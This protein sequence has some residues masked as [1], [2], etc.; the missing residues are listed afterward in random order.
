MGLTKRRES[1]YVEFPVIDNG[2]TITLA[3]RGGGGRLKRWKVGSLNRTLAKQ[4]ETLIKTE[5]LKGLVKSAASES[6]SFKEWAEA[7]LSLDEVKHLAS[8]KDR[9]Q[10]I[11]L[12]LVPF[13]G[14]KLLSEIKPGDVEAYRAQRRLRSGAKASLG[15]VNN[16]HIML[17]H[18]LSVAE[19]RGLIGSNP[20]K[21]VPLPDANNER[22]RVLTDEEWARLYAVA[23]PH[24]QPIMLVAYRL[25]PRLGEILNLTWDRVD[26]GRKFIKLPVCRYQDERASISSID[27][28][29][30]C[31]LGRFR[32]GSAA[33]HK[34]SVLVRRQPSSFDQDRVP[35]SD[36]TGG[37]SGPALS[38]S[39][40]LCGDESPARRGGCGDRHEDCRPQVGA[41]AQ[42]LQQRPG[43][44][45]AHGRW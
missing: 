42:A 36:E 16:D 26:L 41:D 2:E 35:D 45:P 40:S 19:R 18:M 4:Q 21:K 27:A 29:R 44:R 13:F 28:R 37:H 30:V 3:R 11:S 17:K 39:T 14:R 43:E 22:D 33:G 10:T 6:L 31:R 5:L 32:K 24:L 38:R 7:Y 34:S 20:A 12:Q 1:Y 23:A 9:M 15:T 25:G 8:Y